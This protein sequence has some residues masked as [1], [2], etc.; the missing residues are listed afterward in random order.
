M[1]LCSPLCAESVLA[2]LSSHL[3]LQWDRWGLCFAESLLLQSVSLG[4]V[5]P[6]EAP[7][8]RSRAEPLVTVPS[9]AYGP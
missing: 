7:S 6:L 5:A 8:G 2:L 4:T 9:G 1:V 3:S